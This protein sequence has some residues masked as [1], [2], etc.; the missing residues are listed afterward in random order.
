MQRW[1]LAVSGLKPKNTS[2]RKGRFFQKVSPMGIALVVLCLLQPNYHA[3]GAEEA[4][5]N[6]NP[7]T[8]GS[9]ELLGKNGFPVD[10][11]PVGREVTV[12]TDAHSGQRSLRLVRT[13]NTPTP[14]T[15]LNRTKLVTE[16]KGGVDFWYKA[17]SADGAQLNIYVIPVNEEGIERTGSPRATFTVPEDH[18][19]D[20]RWHHARLKYDYTDNPKVKSVHFAAR[21]VGKAGELLLD[22]LQYIP[23]VG[24]L[25]H[26]KKVMLEEDPQTPGQQAQVRVVLTNAGDRPAEN[27]RLSLTMPGDTKHR[28]LEMKIPSLAPDEIK[29]LYFPFMVVR[30]RPM[31]LQATATCGEFED[32]R[33]LELKPSLR[34][35]SFGPA[36]PVLAVGQTAVLECELENTGHVILSGIA[37]TFET[38]AGTSRQIVKTLFPTRRTVVRQTFVPDTET[39]ALPVKVTVYAQGVPIAENAGDRWTVQS[40]L[41][42]V[43]SITPPSPLGRL[44]AA[45]RPIPVLE[46]EHFRL[47][48]YPC[49]QRFFAGRLEVK[50]PQG[51]KVAGWLVSMGRLALRNSQGQ[52]EKYLLAADSCELPPPPA[53]KAGELVFRC[54]LKTKDGFVIRATVTFSAWPGSKICGL[55]ATLESEQPVDILAWGLPMVYIHRRD[56]AIFPGLEWLIDDELSSDSLDIAEDHPDRVRYVVHPYMITIPA[57]GIHGPHGTVGLMWDIR[58]VPGQELSPAVA[59]AS[60]DRFNH[61]RSHLLEL[62]VPPVPE[63]TPVNSR[64]AEKPYRLNSGQKLSLTATLWADGEARDALGVIE[65]YVRSRRVNPAHPLPHSS[66]PNEIVFS[67][68]AY[69]ESLWDPET[70]KW[71]TTKGN[72]LLSNQALPSD[73]AADLVLGAMLTDDQDLKKRCEE[74]LAEV[75]GQLKLPPRLD[76]LRIGGRADRIW[77]NAGRIAALLASRR[78]DGSWRFDADRPGTGPFVGMD[79]REL[80]PHEAL[81]VGTCA[82]N[83]YE[84][85]AFARITADEGLYREMIQTLELMETFRVPRAAQVWEV[86]VHTPDILA[87]ADAVDAYIEAYRLSGERRWLHDAILWAKRGLPFV[88]LWSDPQKPFLQGASIPVFGATWYR[89]SWFGRPVQW[90]G[91]RYANALL[92]LAQYDQS[93]PWK[94]VATIIIHSAVHQQELEGPNVA[95]WP[96][97]ISAID[98]EK[99]P[100]VFAPRQIIG[101]ITKLIGRDEEPRTVYAQLGDHRVALTSL[102]RIEQVRIDAQALNFTVAFPAGEVGP[103]LIANVAAPEE[104]LI[105]GQVVSR[106]DRPHLEK[107]SAWHYDAGMALLTVQVGVSGPAQV[108]IKPAAYRAVDRI[109]RLAEALD[110]RFEAGTEGWV[111]AHD[112]ADLEVK[113]GQLVGRITGP[114]PYIVRPNLRVPAAAYGTVVVRMSTTAGTMAQLFWATQRSPNFDEEKSLRFAVQPDGQMR[115]YR[116]HLAEHPLWKDQ[117]IVALRLD[118]GGGTPDG[119]FRVEGIHGER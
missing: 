111:A 25:P 75:C 68:R 9:F 83:A 106:S 63:F 117:I 16:L 26:I 108:T 102:G 56:E 46:N 35:R 89:G 5:A 86:P 67:T 14:E 104:V 58:S 19:G 38:P 100:W 81:E 59:F 65:E 3:G 50:T 10:W 40:Q 17:V 78:D 36:E 27:I 118:P 92:K 110:F 95:L 112:V 115:E 42:V 99:C 22:D 98:G 113:D 4:T 44:S 119:E 60:P 66:L 76:A 15:G 91:L 53:K 30:N 72:A 90:N 61:Q 64:I 1:E 80:G 51:W 43:K 18:I 6:D 37:V 33:R 31:S 24:P 52:T 88:Y 28:P 47:V 45:P 74:R 73:F 79:Y 13:A 87:A 116:L 7:C 54:P 39:V 96:D 109:P 57:V 77:A 94:E 62:F 11:G 85:L 101:C 105:D 2:G 48:F 71:W 12:S 32:G 20:G 70:R 34:V 114:D 8:N 69:L 103:V 49:A 82:R 84:I 93:L 21:I 23:Q 107:G 41:A 97:N 29:V 55:S